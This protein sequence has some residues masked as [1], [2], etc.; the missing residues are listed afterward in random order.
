M[1]RTRADVLEPELNR[2]CFSPAGTEVDG[3]AQP[4]EG[5]WASSETWRVGS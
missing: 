1:L 3:L 2:A 5:K 4:E